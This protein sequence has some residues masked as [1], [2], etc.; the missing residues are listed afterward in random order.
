[1]KWGIRWYGAKDHILINH[2]RQIPGVDGVVGTLLGKM[3]GDLWTLEKIKA[4]KD[5]VESSGLEL[6]GIESVAV[7][8]AIKAGTEDRD[9]SLIHI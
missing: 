1:M 8:D 9:L 4:L 6:L 3:L 7:A 5:S 2:I